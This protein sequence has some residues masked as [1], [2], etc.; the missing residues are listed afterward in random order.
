MENCRSH[1]WE[2]WNRCFCWLVSIEYRSHSITLNKLNHTV[3]F[4]KV[5]NVF[6]V[7]F[8][9]GGMHITSVRHTTNPLSRTDYNTIKTNLQLSA[10]LD[11]EVERNT[12]TFGNSTH[13]HSGCVTLKHLKID[14]CQA[15]EQFVYMCGCDCMVFNV[16]YLSVK[17][18]QK[19]LNLSVDNQLTMVFNVYDYWN[20]WFN[21]KK[22]WECIFRSS[23]KNYF[24]RKHW[25]P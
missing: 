7:W 3:S 5:E 23:K 19:C 24:Q 1:E 25:A 4:E 20:C 9:S 11:L 15:I 16:L 21:E 6:N 12:K 13:S 22:T 17:Y 18:I 10:Y 8:L 2:I 14:M